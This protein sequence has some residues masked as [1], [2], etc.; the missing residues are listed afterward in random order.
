MYQSIHNSQMFM[1]ICV[2]LI[3][4]CGITAVVLGLRKKSKG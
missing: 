1:F 2:C 3:S 4:L